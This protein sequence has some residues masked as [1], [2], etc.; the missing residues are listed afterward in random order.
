MVWSFLRVSNSI[1][2][3]THTLHPPTFLTA[4]AGKYTRAEST[5]MITNQTN[6]VEKIKEIQG[7]ES[8]EYSQ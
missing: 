4:A 6:R 5:N 2:F 7:T 3:G 8:D 1:G